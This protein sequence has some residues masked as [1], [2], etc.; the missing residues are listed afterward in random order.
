MENTSQRET[1]RAIFLTGFMGAGKST[2]GPLVAER[3]GWQFIDMDDQIVRQAGRSV[4]EIFDS[5]GEAAFR[6]LESGALEAVIAGLETGGEAVIALGGG[7]L[8]EPHNL[9]LLAQAGG[10]TI[11]LDAPVDELLARCRAATIDRPLSRHE[12]QFRQLFSLRKPVYM[13]ADVHVSTANR[14]PAEVADEII[15][16]L[17]PG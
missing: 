17:A 15:R 7:A 13:E 9:W 5:E 10:S 8:T 12:N 16:L 4:A 1:L 3:L 11:F 2:V 14:S 6:K